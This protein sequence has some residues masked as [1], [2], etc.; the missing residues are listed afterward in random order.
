MRF[1]WTTIIVATIAL[2]VGPLFTPAPS[3]GLSGLSFLVAGLMGHYSAKYTNWDVSDIP[4]SY[5][6]AFSVGSAVLAGI[7]GFMQ[8]GGLFALGLFGIILPAIL[9]EYKSLYEIASYPLYG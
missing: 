4:V 7:G 1:L 6:V 2:T 8:I 5:V 9:R 3:F